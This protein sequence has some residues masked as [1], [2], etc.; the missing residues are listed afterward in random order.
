MRVVTI[1][2]FDCPHCKRKESVIIDEE[3]G[4]FC[5]HC[6]QDID[7]KI[8]V[9]ALGHLSTRGFMLACVIIGKFADPALEYAADDLA[10]RMIHTLQVWERAFMKTDLDHP[11]AFELELQRLVDALQDR[12]KSGRWW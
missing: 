6:K 3:S 8:L 7:P 1:D 12:L 2:P 4:I 11:K 9:P 5:N 10:P